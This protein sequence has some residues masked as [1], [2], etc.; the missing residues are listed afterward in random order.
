M[1]AVA[2]LLLTILR[3]IGAYS[4][5]E[6][7]QGPLASGGGGKPTKP[8]IF[9]VFTADPLRGT[10]DCSSVC[11]TVT[12]SADPTCS[13]TSQTVDYAAMVA[14]YHSTTCTQSTDSRCSSA[15]LKATFGNF[16]AVKA[17]YC[18]ADYLVVHSSSA[19]HWTP[20]LDDA[21]TP[22]GGTDTVNGIC[23]TR[24]ASITQTAAVWKIPLSVTM[25]STASGTV[26]NI[27][28]FDGAGDSL[29]SGLKGYLVNNSDTSIFYGL[30]A[31]G[32]VGFTV[33]GQEIYPVHNNRGQ[34]TPQVCPF[35]VEVILLPRHAC[36]F[37]TGL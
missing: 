36:A 14:G 33:G 9:V 20:Y 1:R 8:C 29:A 4:L 21:K 11:S 25:L 18:N 17:A 23:R 30:D 37:R 34:Y 7:C 19:P 26:N 10:G 24:T 15:F 13:F 32:P 3:S 27:A 5:S 16:A 28:A 6:S 12:K 35:S 22:P 31:R 2:F